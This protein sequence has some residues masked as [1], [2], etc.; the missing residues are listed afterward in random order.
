METD[1]E[2]ERDE[3]GVT[4]GHVKS[5]ETSGSAGQSSGLGG[6]SRGL[7]DFGLGATGGSEPINVTTTKSPAFDHAG[8]SENEHNYIMTPLSFTPGTPTYMKGP[9]WYGNTEGRYMLLNFG[10]FGKN[11]NE[12]HKNIPNSE[13]VCNE[14]Q[15]AETQF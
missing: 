13:P 1:S 6:A 8:A 3:V 10:T 15:E 11:K 4:G 14:H 7:G 12:S 5:G 2:G 9:N